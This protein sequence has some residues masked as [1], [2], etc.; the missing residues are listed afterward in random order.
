MAALPIWTSTCV[1]RG[2][3]ETLVTESVRPSVCPFQLTFLPFFTLLALQHFELQPPFCMVEGRTGR[4]YEI[5]AYLTLYANM[6]S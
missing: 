1:L 2:E 3:E 4:K 5:A 6:P